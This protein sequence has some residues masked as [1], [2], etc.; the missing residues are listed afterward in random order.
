[1]VKFLIA[2]ALLM[3]G[4]ISARD[5]NF[6]VIGTGSAMQVSIN[7]QVY[8][9]INKN[10]NEILF[11]STIVNLPDGEINYNYIMDNKAEQFTRVLEADRDYTYNDFYG[12]E[13][14]VVKLEQFPNIAKWTRSIGATSL[15]DDSYIPTVHFTGES[16]DKVYRSGSGGLVE[17]ITFYLKDEVFTFNNLRVSTKN[18]DVSK[19]QIRLDLGD[20]NI[21]GRSILKFRN[22]G[23]DPTNLRQDIYGNMLVAV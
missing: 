20:Q 7:G 4:A 5:V 6:N 16:A 8:N 10:P 3:A 2:S 12:R 13:K 21:H 9:L 15:F 19:F 17:Q 11:S 14:T 18:N 23:E 1:M 22:S